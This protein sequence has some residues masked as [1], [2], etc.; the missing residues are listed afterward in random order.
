MITN[1]KHLSQ[2]AVYAFVAS[3]TIVSLFFMGFF[4]VEPTISHGQSDTAEFSIT[5]TITSESSFLVPPTDVSMVGSIAGVTGGA[6]TGTTQFVVTSNND[7]GY[8]VTIAFE[9]NGTANAMVGDTTADE[10][11]IDYAGDVGGE[12]SYA[13]TPN[14]SAQ[15]AYTVHSSTTLDTDQSF[16]S[17]GSDT[18]NTGSN[19]SAGTS[20]WKEPTTSGFQIVSASDAATTGATSTVTFKLVVPSSPSPVPQSDTYTATATLSLYEQ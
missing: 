10:S 17:N 9:N 5:Q 7:T 2:S 15:F 20:C 19:S 3:V 6:A 4:L 16:L 13:F 18:C 8:Y 12:P 11:I 1:T 14:A